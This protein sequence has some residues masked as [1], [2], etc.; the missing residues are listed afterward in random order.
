MNQSMFI[1]RKGWIGI[2]LILMGCGSSQDQGK[3]PVIKHPTPQPS[4][5]P[6]HDLNTE[7]E[8]GVSREEP[9]KASEPALLQLSDTGPFLFNY[10][11]YT[12]K[13]A[14]AEGFKDARIF[15]PVQGPQAGPYPAL[16]L[17]G[18][19]T[20]TK[21]SVEWLARHL[22]SH[23]FVVAA[24][25]TKNPTSSDVNNWV[26]VQK[27]AVDYFYKI[28]GEPGHEAGTKINTA[29][30]GIVGFS[31]GGLGVLKYAKTAADPRVKAVVSLCPYVPKEIKSERWPITAPSMILAGEIDKVVILD[32][33]TSQQFYQA[34]DAPSKAIYEVKNM[35]HSA[36]ND[37]SLGFRPF[38][39]K[40][41]TAWV[42]A[43]VEGDTRY[44]TQITGSGLEAD[45]KQGWIFYSD[46]KTN[47]QTASLPR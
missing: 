28:A 46:Q 38:V 19:F 47:D 17:S 32:G 7:V 36:I 18:G 44:L 9:V 29:K 30:V 25:T 24:L 6:A 33:L 2:A 13:D 1:I 20:N 4:V 39:V 40:Y 10:T 11:D 42:K 27:G 15:Y 8:T 5:S 22:A 23:G 16:T 21:E 31:M 41:T 3:K 26:D 12:A 14:Q 35:P 43:Y 45:S 34:I 37:S